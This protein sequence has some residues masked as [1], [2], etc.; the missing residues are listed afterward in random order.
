VKIFLDPLVPGVISPAGE[1]GTKEFHRFC[2]ED[3]KTYT[4]GLMTKGLSDMALAGA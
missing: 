4:V 3:I 2:K 1:K